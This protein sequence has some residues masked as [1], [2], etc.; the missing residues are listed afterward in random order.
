MLEKKPI[1]IPDHNEKYRYIP[2]SLR[3][4]IPGYVHS[5]GIAP[6]TTVTAK[7]PLM[8]ASA[9]TQWNYN[10]AVG[11]STAVHAL[12]PRYPIF[13][14]LSGRTGVKAVTKGFN[15]YKSAANPSWWSQNYKRVLKSAMA[16]KQAKEINDLEK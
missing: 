10:K 7:A 1:S 9:N 15:M 11:N 16:I 13:D 5:M 12:K 3:S 6:E 2:P 4:K 14:I 8:T